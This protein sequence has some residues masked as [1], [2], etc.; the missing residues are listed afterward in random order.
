MVPMNSIAC[1]LLAWGNASATVEAPKAHQVVSAPA[2]EVMQIKSGLEIVIKYAGKPMTVQL[3]GIDTPTIDP[4]WKKVEVLNQRNHLHAL[5]Q[6]GDKVG[7]GSV[8]RVQ[9]YARNQLLAQVRRASDGVWLNL[10]MLEQ[11]FATTSTKQEFSARADFAAAEQRAKNGRLGM[12]AP[13]FLKVAVQPTRF[14]P[15]KNAPKLRRIAQAQARA[16]PMAGVRGNG[17]GGN[18]STSSSESSSSD[19]GKSSNDHDDPT[20]TPPSASDNATARTSWQPQ[21]NR[22]SSFAP[23]WGS[24]PVSPYQNGG[25]FGGGTTATP[26]AGHYAGYAHPAH[27]SGYGGGGQTASYGSHS[28][29]SYGSSSSSSSGSSSSSSSSTSSSSSYGSSSASSYG[30]S[31]HGHH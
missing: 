9:P 3:L 12:W 2:Y 15:P 29:S 13:D 22:G 19:S 14:V 5:I 17:R 20:P 26:G 18:A 11:G 10:A 1:L 24:T 4:D 8:T 31:A 16:I 30:G 25:S 6:T 21:R 27:S 7:L 28:S 23:F